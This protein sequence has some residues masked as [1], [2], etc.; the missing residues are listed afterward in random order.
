MPQYGKLEATDEVCGHCGA[1]LVVVTTNRGPWK[2][3][4]NYDCPG[5]AIEAEEKARKAEERAKAKAAGKKA[6]AKR[7]APA[8]KAASKSKSAAKDK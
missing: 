4:P 5:K 2:L 8:K 3:C 1:P 6:P 7:K